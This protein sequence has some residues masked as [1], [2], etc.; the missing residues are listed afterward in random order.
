[1]AD[2]AAVDDIISLKRPLTAAESTKAEA[3]IPVVCNCLREE[4]KRVGK[5]LDALVADDTCL[6][7]A[8]KSVTVDIVMRELLSDTEDEQ[9]SQASE[10]ALGY[11]VSYTVPN[12]GGGLFIKNAELARLGLRRQR[13]GV[14]EF[15]GNA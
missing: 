6:A 3:L 2:Y 13:Y 15:Y 7:S 14:I 10:S 12:A 4:A 11:S 9:V 1:M 5:D 8:A